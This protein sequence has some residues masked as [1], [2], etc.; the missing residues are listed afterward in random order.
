MTTATQHLST[1]R[2]YNHKTQGDHMYQL[3]YEKAIV[4]TVKTEFIPC[5]L[6]V[7]AGT[8]LQANSIILRNLQSF[9]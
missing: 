5:Y 8:L 6:P 3:C 7:D 4:P 1:K 9:N 2:F